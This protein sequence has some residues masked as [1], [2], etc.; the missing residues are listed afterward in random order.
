MIDEKYTEECRH[1]CKNM[2]EN[3]EMIEKILEFDFSENSW[4]MVKECEQNCKEGKL[5]STTE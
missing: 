4:N 3:M 5:L 1:E 2:K